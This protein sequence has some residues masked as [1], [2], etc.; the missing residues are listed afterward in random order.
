MK[1]VLSRKG[2]DSASGGYPSPIL[3]DGTL[4]SIPIPSMRY[5]RNCSP[6]SI[7]VN[8]KTWNN[9]DFQQLTYSE[10]SLPKSTKQYFKTKNLNLHSYRDV[11]DNILPKGMI[12][13][14]KNYFPKECE[15]TCHFDPD[16]IPSVLPRH[17]N[18]SSLFGQA[19]GSES[20]LQ[21]NS[22]KEGDLF[23][24]FGWFRKTHIIDGALQFDSN[25]KQG[26]H[27]IYGYMQIDCKFSKTINQENAKSWMNYHPHFRYGL[28][29][30]KLNAVYVGRKSLS[31]D[32]NKPGF[33]IFY[34][35]QDLVLTD[36][37][38][39]NNPRRNR[40]FWRYELFPKDLSITYHKSKN[41]NVVEIENG[42]YRKYFK[43]TDR[44]QEFV[45]TN[46]KKIINWVK[47][48]IQKNNLVL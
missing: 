15:W 27:L 1:V 35:H 46:P 22:V 25:D 14:G 9:Q 39:R 28:W 37:T 16:L 36:T 30:D 13:Q 24:F 12:K 5:S 38:L 31:W 18:W 33:G 11:L 2:F 3:P 45:I 42:E 4:L 44:G 26:V 21:K 10:L 34:Y 41:W 19:S 17:K 47:S 23:L 43:S 20:H 7:G 8:W 32:I 6:D 48:L 29:N 40:S